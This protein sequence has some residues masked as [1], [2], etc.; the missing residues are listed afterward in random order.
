MAC[1]GKKDLIF[2]RHVDTFDHYHLT[3]ALIAHGS[4][5]THGGFPASTAARDTRTYCQHNF[6]FWP[7]ILNTD[8]ATSE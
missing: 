6:M 4:S 8:G 7:S 3:P 1:H 5:V 2:P